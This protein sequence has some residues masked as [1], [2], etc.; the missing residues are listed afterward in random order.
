LDFG[1]RLEV[2]SQGGKVVGL[3]LSPAMLDVARDKSAGMSNVRWVQGDMR[4]FDLD[5]TFGL[6]T[7]PGHAFQNTLTAADQFAC[8]ASIRRRL[9]P[10]GLLVVHLDHPEVGWLG[11]LTRADPGFLLGARLD[12]HQPLE[13]LIN[14]MYNLSRAERHCPDA[15]YD[16][17]HAVESLTMRSIPE[18]K[19]QQLI[20]DL[21]GAR[22]EVLAAAMLLGVEAR[23]EHKHAAQIWEF[24]ARSEG[25]ES[26][27]GS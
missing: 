15:M 10:G 27:T 19:K 14:L 20:A 6:A 7:I 12:Q 8:L 3:D 26:E 18:A 17:F 2:Q 5:E 16:L 23:D 22:H 13:I 1:E 21:A 24:A 9:V 25:D 4:S 11:D